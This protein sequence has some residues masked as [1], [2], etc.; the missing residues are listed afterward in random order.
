ME[1]EPDQPL[2]SNGNVLTHD[3]LPSAG[4]LALQ[5][6]K[7]QQIPDLRACNMVSTEVSAVSTKSNKLGP[8]LWGP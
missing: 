4:G 7:L 1:G 8:C 2:A 6:G 3:P 5:L